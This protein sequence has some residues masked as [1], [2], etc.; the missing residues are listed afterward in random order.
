MADAVEEHEARAA[1]EAR[2][3]D[4][5]VVGQDLL[6]GAVA[7]HRREEGLADGPGSGPGREVRA[8]AEAA[9]VVDAGDDLE[10]AAVLEHHPAHDVH[11]P[12]LHRPEALPA[13]VVGALP[14]ALLR[15]DQA[16][17]Q[18]AAVHRGAPGEM[19][20]TFAFEVMEQRPWPPARMLAAEGHD[21]RLDLGSDAVGAGRGAV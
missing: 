15:L 6:G 7:A 12:E 18:E 17:T 9:V 3:E 1:P 16:V 5:A 10:L 13:A 20:H 2:R 8:D 11:L 14:A 19:L 4:L 21:P